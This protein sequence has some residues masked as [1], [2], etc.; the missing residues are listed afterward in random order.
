MTAKKHYLLNHGCFLNSTN[1]KIVVNLATGD[2][3]NLIT[4]ELKT[5]YSPET[6]KIV[7][8]ESSN[9]LPDLVFQEMLQRQQ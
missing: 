8:E 6:Q 3:L 2:I 5:R 9:L 7:L 4:Q 1:K